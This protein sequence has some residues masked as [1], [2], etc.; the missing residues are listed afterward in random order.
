MIE[1]WMSVR[2]GPRVAAL[3]GLI[4]T[5]LTGAVP[6]RASAGTLYG[7][8]PGNTILHFDTAAPGTPFFGVLITG[9]QPGEAALAIDLR[10]ATGQ[11]YLLG[12]TSRLYVVDPATGAAAAV[13]PPFTPALAG[14]A[15]G[16]DFH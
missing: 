15:S 10:P 16:F 3:A 1:S 7:L 4:V 5:A 12:S 8:T 14:V 11:L 2:R 13:G 9:L 6:A